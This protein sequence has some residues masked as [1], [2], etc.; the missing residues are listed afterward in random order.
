MRA[1]VYRSGI[2]AAPTQRGCEAS[3]YLLADTHKPAGRVGRTEAIFTSPTLEGVG[4]WVR[5]NGRNTRIA[6]IRVREIAVNPDG[7]WVYSIDAWEAASHSGVE[8]E[9]DKGKAKFEAYWATGMTLT[10]W[11]ADGTLDAGEWECLLDTHLVLGQRPVSAK[12]V[13]AAQTDD[14]H[15]RVIAGLLR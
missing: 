12:R 13:V 15:A 1:K 8:Y 2:V 11:L 6:D 14:Y 9:I 10:D 7:V 5:G 4:R 3:V